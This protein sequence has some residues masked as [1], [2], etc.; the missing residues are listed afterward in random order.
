MRFET[1]PRKP[2]PDEPGKF[3]TPKSGDFEL[4]EYA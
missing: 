3:S 1:M 2:K 4:F